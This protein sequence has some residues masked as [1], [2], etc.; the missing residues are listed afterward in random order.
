MSFSASTIFC[1]T[2]STLAKKFPFE[3][4][5]HSGKQKKSH[6][7]QDWVDQEGGVWDQVLFGQ[8]LLNI[9]A[10]WA[11]VLSWWKNQSPVCHH[12]MGKCVERVFKNKFTEAEHNLSQQHQLVH[13]YRWV[14]TTLTQ[15]GKPVL[16]GACP[17]E[18]NS[19]AFWGV[20][21]CS[22]VCISSFNIQSFTNLGNTVLKTWVNF[23]FLSE[24]L[25]I[26]FYE[27]KGTICRR[28][29]TN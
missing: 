15:L 16:Q 25:Y 2:S 9:S 11:G 12:E 4:F 3:D 7:G 29:S 23:P 5:F 10:V 17:P 6:L 8:K 14:P 13:W 21:P 26:S 1:F 27:P 22:S 20:P 19:G 24:L 28:K 18:D